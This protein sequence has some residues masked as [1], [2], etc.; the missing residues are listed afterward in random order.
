MLLGAVTLQLVTF[1]GGKCGP[2]LPCRGPRGGGDEGPSCRYPLDV[3][4]GVHICGGHPGNARWLKQLARH[5]LQHQPLRLLR[6]RVGTVQTLDNVQNTSVGKNILYI[7]AT[8]LLFRYN[9]SMLRQTKK[10]VTAQCWSRMKNNK[11]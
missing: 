4:R 3:E 6:A 10:Y 11:Y 8:R 2:H 9:S 5:R 1:V 7:G